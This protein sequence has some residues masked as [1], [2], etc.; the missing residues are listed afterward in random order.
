MAAVGWWRC[1]GFAAASLVCVGLGVGC[2]SDSKP[3]DP[4]TGAGLMTT[5]GTDSEGTGTDTAEPEDKIDLPP[6]GA[7]D[8]T[9]DGG[10]EEECASYSEAAESELQ[11]ADIIFI[12]DNSGSMGDEANAV[13]A[14]LNNFSQ[15]IIDSGVDAHVVLI[16]SYPGNGNG[17]CV[18]PPLGS[19]GCNSADSNPPTYLH[20][21]EGVGSHDALQRLLGS[22]AQWMPVVRPDSGLHVVVVTDD[23]SNLDALS[24]D[25]QFKA[26]NPDFDDYKLHGIVSMQD[27]SDAADIGQVYISLGQLTG[28][29]VSDLC[30]QNFQP[31]F[32]LLATE[33][34]SGSVL[35][36]EWAV[37]EP[38]EGEELDPDKV[39]IEFDDGGGNL[40]TI[41]RVDNSG[42][43]ANVMD[44]WY[45]D[46]PT[47]PTTIYACPQTCDRM[48]DAMMATI[49]I[50]LGC[51]TVPAG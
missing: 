5:A 39:N 3:R 32:D 34:I 40:L 27:C 12:V 31:V 13:Q 49:Q 20:I 1:G 8:G 22:S 48:Q 33:V 14:N 26:L 11:P 6:D 4:D 29:L 37:P 35:S 15:Q 46:N 47:N 50:Q 42:Q 24:F 38:P 18:E 17:I 28:G 2:G 7:T 9:P 16:S 36:C 44:G 45:Y 43:C 25:S 41:G 30:L 19:G 10:D 51:A 23:E 21:D